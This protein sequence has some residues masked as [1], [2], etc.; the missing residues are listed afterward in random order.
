[1]QNKNIY[2]Y[3][4]YIYI[5]LSRNNDTLDQLRKLNTLAWSFRLIIC[6]FFLTL[7]VSRL[8][9]WSGGVV[10]LYQPLSDYDVRCRLENSCG[11]FTIAM[12]RMFGCF[13]ALRSVL[14]CG[15]NLQ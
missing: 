5:H 1:M 10:L 8:G 9:S 14:R 11:G 7:L 3:H 15:N 12:V 13:T 2:K 4:I 6:M